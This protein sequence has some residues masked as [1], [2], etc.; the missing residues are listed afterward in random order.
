MLG[1]IAIQFSGGLNGICSHLND[2]QKVERGSTFS[3]TGRNAIVQDSNAI[4]T[5]VCIRFNEIPLRWKLDDNELCNSIV[6]AAGEAAPLGA[7][8][9]TTAPS[10]GG[11]TTGDINDF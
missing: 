8:T 2:G 9:T 4:F 3:R 5:Q 11:D 10:S 1:F 6:E 7:T